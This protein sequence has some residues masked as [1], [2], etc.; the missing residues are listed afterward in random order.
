MQKNWQ[1]RKTEV[2]LFVCMLLFSRFTFA[3]FFSLLSLDFTFLRLG[4]VRISRTSKDFLI[5]I[6]LFEFFL[7]M[8]IEAL[9]IWMAVIKERKAGSPS[10]HNFP[11]F[12]VRQRALSTRAG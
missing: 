9:T 4:K 6:R 1:D 10:S 5:P 2:V 3:W 12:G 11:F 7:Q 8:Q